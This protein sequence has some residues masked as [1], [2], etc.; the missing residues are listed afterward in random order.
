MAL[1]AV[2]LAVTIA[3][4]VPSVQRV[5]SPR[6]AAD[7]RAVMNIAVTDNADGDEGTTDSIC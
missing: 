7:D 4:S 6:R 5:A 1:E 2:E 3:V